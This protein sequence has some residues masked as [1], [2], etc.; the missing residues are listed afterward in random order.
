MSRLLHHAVVILALACASCGGDTPT[1]PED[2]G[3]PAG[4][5]NRTLP[6]SPTGPPLRDPRPPPGEPPL[7]TVGN[8]LPPFDELLQFSD[9]QTGS[10]WNLRG[11]AVSGPLVGEKLTPLQSVT[12][13]WFGWSSFWQYGGVYGDADGEGSI[14]PNRFV[15]VPEDEFVGTLPPDAIPPLDSPSQGLGTANFRLA[16]QAFGVDDGDL[17]IGFVHNGDARAYPVN[18]L[19]WHE[20]VNHSVGGDRVVVTYCPITASAAA[21][22]PRVEGESFLF[23][24]TGSLYNNNLLMYDRTSKSFWSQLLGAAVFGFHAGSRLELLTVVQSTW[25]AWKTLYPDTRILSSSTVYQR[26]YGVDIYDISTYRTNTAILF[27]QRPH[28]DPR[29]HP[30]EMV[31]GLIGIASAKA[32]PYVTFQGDAVINDRFEGPPIVALFQESAQLATAFSSYV[33]GRELTFK[34]N[35]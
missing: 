20:I 31:F 26:D 18:I 1:S 8:E 11:E 3:P 5:A 24:N 34:L 9:H 13:Y 29:F 14:S 35:N 2:T 7:T 10:V 15:T 33:A 32:Y 6:E 12:A 17:V 25:A 4:G 23:G 27:E 16:S 22:Q 19:N 21:F 28:I 30:K